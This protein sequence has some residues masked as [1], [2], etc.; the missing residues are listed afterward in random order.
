M[1][2]VDELVSRKAYEQVLWERDLAI[3]QLKELG[4][5]FGEKTDAEEFIERKRLDAVIERIEQS[6]GDEENTM[7]ALGLCGALTIIAEEFGEIKND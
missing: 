2:S 3:T 6:A 4:H 5:E 7:I 1:K